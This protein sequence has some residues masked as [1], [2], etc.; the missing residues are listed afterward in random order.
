MADLFNS[1]MGFGPGAT[2]R[3]Q[4]S[5]LVDEAQSD[6][7]PKGAAER[8][9]DDPNTLDA[10]ERYGTIVRESKPGAQEPA[11]MEGVL[12]NIRRRDLYAQ[13][14]LEGFQERYGDY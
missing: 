3:K 8:D 12:D 14:L 2:N 7:E 6:Y 10:M 11:S 9:P 13:R 1:R 5:D 4:P